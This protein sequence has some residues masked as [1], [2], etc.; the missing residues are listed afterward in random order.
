MFRSMLVPI[1]VALLLVIFIQKMW[2]RYQK[3]KRYK[4]PPSVPGIPVLG[5]TLQ[6]PPIMQGQWA[7]QQAK[8]Y[9]EM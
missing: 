8:K 2:A 4:L 1:S 6:M 9:G 7:L 3:Q 5:N